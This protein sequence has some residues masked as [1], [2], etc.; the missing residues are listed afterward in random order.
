MYLKDRSPYLNS[1][2]PYSESQN[3]TRVNL[4][5]TY[6]TI[7]TYLKTYLSTLPSLIHIPR[8]ISYKCPWHIYY[9]SYNKHGKFDK[10]LPKAATLLSAMTSGWGDTSITE[11]LDINSQVVI[12]GQL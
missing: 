7:N 8:S 9:P 3:I 1:S 2:F 5:G 10:M 12:K 4:L 11:S 6:F